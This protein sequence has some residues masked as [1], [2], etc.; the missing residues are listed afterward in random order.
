MVIEDALLPFFGKQITY[1]A[2]MALLGC[3]ASTI[4]AIVYAVRVKTEVRQAFVSTAIIYL[5][6]A[7]ATFFS[8]STPALLRPFGVI[9][10]TVGVT[11][12]YVLLS[13]W[14]HQPTLAVFSAF[15]LP[16]YLGFTKFGCFF[17]GCCYGLPT[18]GDFSVT[19]GF[20]TVCGHT[21]TPLFPLQL[22]TALLL[23]GLAIIVLVIGFVRKQITMPYL[24]LALMLMMYLG[25]ACLG[26]PNAN[27]MI[28]NGINFALILFWLITAITV[29]GTI[30]YI[31][32]K[33]R[34]HKE[35]FKEE[36]KK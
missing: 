10:G 24:P 27:R 29:G 32:R 21:G 36:R 13:K 3:A 5:L 26:D 28:L 1:Y 7:C 22:F 2:L 18:K 4:M 20:H 14:W 34:C 30:G 25:C 17:T 16:M 12:V 23:V 9:L 31:L 8:A 19:Y 35:D 6:G 11:A 15:T 33:R